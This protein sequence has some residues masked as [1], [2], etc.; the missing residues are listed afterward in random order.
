MPV[1]P[2]TLP[3]LVAALVTLGVAYAGLRLYP[4]ELPALP[5][6]DR[7]DLLA[8]VFYDQAM[9]FL[10]RIV[11]LCAAAFAVLSIAA[12][13]WNREWLI[14]A[15]PFE[16]ERA[17]ARSERE[18]DELRGVLADLFVAIARVRQTEEEV[19]IRSPA[20]DAG[21]HVHDERRARCR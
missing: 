3:R 14:K 16:V 8:T 15:G 12:R 19:G 5:A 7:G 2:F 9:V 4:A 17:A 6:G 18:L 21:H 20:P 1:A 10:L 11:F 13:I